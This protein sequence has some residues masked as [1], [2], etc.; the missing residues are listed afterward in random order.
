[1]N[2]E[3][4]IEY[5]ENICNNVRKNIIR[6][7]YNAKSGHPGGSLSAVEIL[8]SLYKSIMDITLDEEGKRI[9]KFILSKGHASALYY[10][11]LSECG[12]IPK[13]D[14][15][16]FRKYDS[17]LEGHPSNKIP[18]VDVSSGS[19]GQGLSIANGMALEKKLYGKKGYVYCLLGDGELEEGQIWEALM[20]S[21][22]YNLN[23]LIIFVDYNGLQIDGTIKE[24]KS[25]EN[26]NQKFE[27]FGLNVQTINGN[28]IN[29]IIHA[30][31]NAKEILN[32]RPNVII[33]NTVKGKGVSFMENKAEWH[34]KA[35][36]N[37]QF[38]IAIKELER[39]R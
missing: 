36:N 23:N 37:E 19:L 5:L 32:D 15:I 10:A 21:N 38:N 30:V 4:N 9:D 11:V 2:K 14:L 12:F 13:D 29:Q 16:T 31:K 22:K 17:Y 20:S 34:G 7:I 18:G 39:K 24:V 35:L 1:M 26:I 6:M 3:K 27:S 25:I 28:D 8:V 33:A